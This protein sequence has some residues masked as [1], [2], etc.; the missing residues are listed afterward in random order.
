MLNEEEIRAAIVQTVKPIAKSGQCSVYGGNP[1]PDRVIH[2]LLWVLLGKESQPVPL[3]NK[4]ALGLFLKDVCGIPC[5]FFNAAGKT[6]I[7]W[8][9]AWMEAHGLSM[10]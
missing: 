2:G 9:D 5:R 7:I 10:D 3:D 1:R 8:D 6:T 4:E